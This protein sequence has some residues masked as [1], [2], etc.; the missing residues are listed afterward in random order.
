MK[1]PR[2]IA[3]IL[4][5]ILLV[6][7]FFLGRTG[8]A[9]IWSGD[10]VGALLGIAVLV[11]PFIGVWVIWREVRFGF[12]TQQ[13]AAFQSENPI[14]D[15][16]LDFAATKALVE[17]QPDSWEAW[18]RV[19]IAYDQAGDRRKARESMHHAVTLYRAQ[20]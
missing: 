14:E 2:T 3:L 12:T 10:F 7:L 9:L 1:S 20:T 18:F 5:G 8:V 4:A 15:Q 11:F 6:Y 19:S 13:M 16:P 17:E